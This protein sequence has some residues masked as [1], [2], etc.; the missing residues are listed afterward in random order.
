MLKRKKGSKFKNVKVVIDSITFDSKLESNHYIQ[1]RDA[2]FDMEMQTVYRLQESF[3]HQGKLVRAITYKSDFV[4]KL[5]Y[6]TYVIDSKGLL[7][8]VFKIKSKM[9]LHSHGIEIICVSSM[10][11]M[12][13]VIERIK[14]YRTTR[15]IVQELDDIKK[16]RKKEKKLKKEGKQ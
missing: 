6:E 15:E 11:A 3:L 16:A 7:T 5:P 2:G 13:M 14:D 4:L 1:L 8:E 10:K 12:E 9:L